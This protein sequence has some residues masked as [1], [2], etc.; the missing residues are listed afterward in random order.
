MDQ[1]R[2]EPDDTLDSY[3][4]RIYGG[5]VPGSATISWWIHEHSVVVVVLVPCQA[6][7]M[8]GHT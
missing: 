7:D 3:A 6:D 5:T 2:G 4:K 1:S 8:Y